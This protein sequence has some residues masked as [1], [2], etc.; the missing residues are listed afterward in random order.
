MRN[1]AKMALSC[2][3]AILISPKAFAISGGECSPGKNPVLATV[4]ENQAQALLAK[5]AMLAD[6]SDLN[7]VS[8]KAYQ[9]QLQD[10]KSKATKVALAEIEI[11]QICDL[12]TGFA[13]VDP[14]LKNLNGPFQQFQVVITNGVQ[15]E[16]RDASTKHVP[17]VVETNITL[18][19]RVITLN[20]SDPLNCSNV[21][22][23]YLDNV[24]METLRGYQTGGFS[25]A[26]GG[27]K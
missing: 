4:N 15:K 3:V 14:I 18:T 5:M 16:L 8:W 20:C 6:S 17:V 22:Q 23:V 26:G 24:S 21:V 10:M 2:L 25:S 13:K 12:G 7:L 11:R 1:A 19:A 9:Q 27:G